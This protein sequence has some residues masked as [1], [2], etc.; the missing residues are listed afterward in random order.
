PVP[1]GQGRRAGRAAVLDSRGPSGPHQPTG[2]VPVR[3]ALPVCAGPVPRGEA[4]ASGREA[5]APVRVL[6]PGGPD[7]EERRGGHRRGGAAPPA[8]APVSG[9]GSLLSVEHLVKDFPVTKG[10]VLQ[11]R[12]GWVSAVAN[13]SFGI[14]RGE[15]FGL[16]GESGCGKTTI[17]RLIVGLDRPTSG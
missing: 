4:Q 17:G 3:A 8:A 6:L 7:G 14:R 11:R 10:A 13:V 16:V 12:V 2:G 1:A 9:D 5:G 15:T